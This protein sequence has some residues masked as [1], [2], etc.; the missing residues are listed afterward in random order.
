[1]YTQKRKK[2]TKIDSQREIRLHM[3]NFGD[4]EDW[5]LWSNEA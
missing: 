5:I 3:K 4:E 1:M 2:A